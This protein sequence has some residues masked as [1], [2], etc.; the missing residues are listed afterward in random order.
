LPTW[1][2]Y[3]NWWEKKKRKVL[4]DR[5]DRYK[6]DKEYRDCIKKNSCDRKKRLFKEKIKKGGDVNIFVRPRRPLLISFNGSSVMMYGIGTLAKSLG[7]LPATI[8]GWEKK[9]VVPCTPFRGRNKV[10]LYTKEMIDVV[11]DAFC[12]SIGNTNI[13]DKEGFDVTVRQ[14]WA[15][16]LIPLG[17]TIKV[18]VIECVEEIKEE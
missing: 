7:K 9:G 1:K 8:V 2:G 4:D 15:D 5:A 14:G 12:K 11:K 16:L 10:R 17:K 13:V 6:N 3:K 18:E